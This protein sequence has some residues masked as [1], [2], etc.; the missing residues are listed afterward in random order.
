MGADS[1]FRQLWHKF[2]RKKQEKN[3]A[4]KQQV[5]LAKDSINEIKYRF[6]FVL[7]YRKYVTIQ[8]K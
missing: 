1:T 3:Y 5:I 8:I 6:H 2:A 7:F 4:Q